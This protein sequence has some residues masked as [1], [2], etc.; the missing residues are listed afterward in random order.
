MEERRRKINKESREEVSRKRK[1]E[2]RKGEDET[3]AV[4]RRC[5]NPVS[6]EAFDVFSQWE[7]SESSGLSDCGSEAS[8]GVPVVTDVPVSP[9]STAVVMSE[10]LVSDSDWEV[11]EPQSFSFSRKRGAVCVENQENMRYEG[12]PVEAPL[13]SRRKSTSLPPKYY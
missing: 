8:S 13:A 6:D 5:T 10:A 1:R 7:D 3:V 2:G 11:V 9:S 12:T 4:K